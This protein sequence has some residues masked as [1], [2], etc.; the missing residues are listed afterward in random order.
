LRAV[1]IATKPNP[2]GEGT[3]SRG[4]GFLEYE[5]AEQCSSALMQLQGMEIDGHRVKLKSSTRA[6][7]AQSGAT[8]KK[9]R[10]ILRR[11][12]RR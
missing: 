12:A 4:F 5:S 9:K 8:E 10:E 6:S 3:L 7:A 2:K 1:T 11:D